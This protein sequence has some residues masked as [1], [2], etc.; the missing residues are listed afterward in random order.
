[1]KNKLIKFLMLIVSISLICIIGL[2]LRYRLQ[3]GIWNFLNNPDRINCY[4][5]R[6]YISKLE[7]TDV[8]KN[9]ERL[10]L[11][12]WPVNKTLKT[13]YMVPPGRDMKVPS[14]IYL[15]TKDGKF[16]S[17]GLSGSPD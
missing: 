13:L 16:Q 15:K 10:E 6:Y 1:M 3:F 14:A 4:G 11:I 17:Y 7:P 2:M 12:K 8:V 9:Q 5:R